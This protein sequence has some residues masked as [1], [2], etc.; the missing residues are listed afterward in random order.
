MNIYFT[1]NMKNIVQGSQT[2]PM[3]ASYLYI[4]LFEGKLINFK[5]R[6]P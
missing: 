4:A 1:R 2:N 5:Y 6:A 3:T